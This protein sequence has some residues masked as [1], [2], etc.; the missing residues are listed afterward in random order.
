MKRSGRTIT[1][2]R[3][4]YRISSRGIDLFLGP[5][6]FQAPGSLYGINIVQNAPG[7]IQVGSFNFVNARFRDLYKSLDS[8]GRVI[9]VSDQLQWE[10]K[11]RILV[12]VRTLQAQLMRPDPNGAVLRQLWSSIRTAGSIG[13]FAALIERISELLASLI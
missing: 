12:D 9:L 2:K 13:A 5:S 4:T 11:I 10:D 8:L 3:V 1:S 7:I 6:Q